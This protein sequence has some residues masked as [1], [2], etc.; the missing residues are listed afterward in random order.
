[1]DSEDKS[2]FGLLLA[3]LGETFDKD[4]TRTRLEAYWIGLG[5][6]P[7][8]QFETA[9]HAAL[10]QCKF[11]PA[12]AELREL[13][14]HGSGND[15]AVRAFAIVLQT[16]PLGPY[17]HVCFQDGVINATIRNQGGWPMFLGRFDGGESEKWARLEFCKT[18]ASLVRAGVN[19]DAARPLPGINEAGI[20]AD[21][22]IGPPKVLFIKC[23]DAV[24]IAVQPRAKFQTIQIKRA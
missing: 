5:D 14:G 23:A 15:A 16:I 24:A 10:R 2:R 12:P 13:A 3:L 8:D 11:F 7:A 17:K 9:V 4:I 22:K 6:L 1:M 18:Y 21:G 20:G 19:D